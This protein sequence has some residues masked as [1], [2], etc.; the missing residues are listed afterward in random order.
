[1]S[2]KDAAA[3]QMRSQQIDQGAVAAAPNGGL[4]SF[5]VFDTILTRLVGEPSSLFLLLGQAIALPELWHGSP[6]QF[7]AARVNAEARARRHAWPR[8]VTLVAIYREVGRSHDLSAE[9]CERIAGLEVALERR[10]IRA[11]PG[12]AARLEAV[13]AAG[14]QVLFISDMYLPHATLRR[15]LID[16]GALHAHEVLW[17][18]SEHGVTKGGGGGMYD[19][20]RKAGPQALTDWVHRGDNEHAD[21]LAPA[22]LGIRTEHYIDCH[23]TPNEHLMEAASIETGG[24]SSLLAGAARWTRLSRPEATDPALAA[25]AA[26]TAAPIVYAF[27]LWVL[28]EAKKRGLA[29]IWFMARDGQVM[30]PVARAIAARLGLDIDVGYLYGGRQVVRVASLVAVDDTA[31]DWMTGGAGVMTLQAVLDRVGLQQAAVR[32][33][34]VE[35]QLP[36]DA[37]LGWDA[38]PRL[39]RFLQHPT[40]SSL[41]LHEAVARRAV[42]LDYFQA[43]GLMNEERCAVVDI[44]WRGNVLKSIVDLIGPAQASR[45]TFL[46]FGLYSHP[47]G[48]EGVP[49]LAYLFDVDGQQRLGT[50][51]DIPSLTTLM[52]IV[53]QADH[54]S[55]M[56]LERL[57]DGF[58]PVCRPAEASSSRWSVPQFQRAAVEFANAVAIEEVGCVDADLRGVCDGLLRRLSLS[59]NADE[60]ALLAPLGFVDDQ[61]GSEPQPF[62]H[63]YGWSEVR[64]AYRTGSTSPALGLNWWAAAATALTPK[65][66]KLA[67][68]IAAKLGRLRV[69]RRS[70]AATA[71]G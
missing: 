17:V 54:G 7:A 4:R 5:D 49:K 35:M 27:V 3:T 53:C 18:S 23:L 63:G 16:L 1:M 33:V 61:G 2:I 39:K 32:H 52:E 42:V 46:Y 50:G 58:A 59:P 19:A 11:V 70:Q 22:R 12:A 48:C 44:G 65:S 20:V 40:V 28:L 51:D 45:H 24:L 41:V 15:W 10:L 29:R 60:V 67:M 36:V 6:E 26:G 34:A 69:K 21:V 71:A 31:L 9:Q 43:C 56:A 8:E 13:R 30:L 14:H 37:P 66:I 62:A 64:L 47:R 55:V 68:R 38:I 57:G 25:V